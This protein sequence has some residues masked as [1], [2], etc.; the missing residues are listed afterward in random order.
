MSK[1]MVS[2]VGHLAANA[3]EYDAGR[4]VVVPTA[5]A[6]SGRGTA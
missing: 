1:R 2:I 6:E 5:P 4:A 3:A